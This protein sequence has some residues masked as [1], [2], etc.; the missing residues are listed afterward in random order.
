MLCARLL[1][2]YCYTKRKWVE[3]RQSAWRWRGGGA[4]HVAA[5]V[6]AAQVWRVG[7]SWHRLCGVVSNCNAIPRRGIRNIVANFNFAHTFRS[8]RVRRQRAGVG[9][10]RKVS[11]AGG[12]EWPAPGR[13]SR[14]H[15][16]RRRP[17]NGGP[18]IT[19]EQFL[20]RNVPNEKSFQRNI[21]SKP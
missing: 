2:V 3:K 10:G 15:A 14:R 21:I 12:V 6:Y 20:R 5:G 13:A 18:S 1:V 17:P 11:R 16:T 4:L 7:P 9:G 19:I 8:A